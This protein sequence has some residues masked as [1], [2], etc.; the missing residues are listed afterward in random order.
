VNLR[1]L[2]QQIFDL[3][4][5]IS[6]FA[7]RAGPWR[8]VG[9]ILFAFLYYSSYGL[10]GLELRGEG[11]TIAIIAQRILEGERPL[12]DTFLGYNVF[13]FYPIVALFAI[14]GPNF[15]V[16]RLFFYLLSIVTGVLGYRAVWR[17]S[18]RPL[19]SLLAAVIIILIPGMQFRTYMGLLAV[20]NL[21]F[22]LEVFA[23]KNS[24]RSRLI[25]LIGSGLFLGLTFLVRIDLGILFSML[26]LGSLVV[27]PLIDVRIWKRRTRFSA[28]ALAVYAILIVLVQIPVDQFAAQTGFRNEFRSQYVYWINDVTSYLNTVSNGAT[29]VFGEATSSTGAKA[30]PAPVP[31]PK[32]GS[33]TD[34]DS[35]SDHRTRPRPP[36]SD[37][38]LASSSGARHLAF[39]IYYPIAGGVIIVV[40]STLLFLN[41]WRTGHPELNREGFVLLIATGSAL[42]L[43]PQYFLFRPDPPHVSE[44][45]CPFVIAAAIAFHAALPG[46]HPGSR[47]IRFVGVLYT[48]L[49]TIHIAFYIE[50]GIKRPS[51]G[52]CA[53]K[54][55]AEVFFKADNGVSGYLPRDKAAEYQALYQT[56]ID[57][58]APKDYVVCFPYQPMVNFMTNRRSYLY[59]LYVDN[60]SAPPKF[61]EQAIAE[62]AKYKP[63]A[64]LI[65]DVAMNQIPASRFTVWAAPVYQYIKDHYDYAATEAGNEIYLRRRVKPQISQIAPIFG[66]DR[67]PVTFPTL[68]QIRVIC[69]ICGLALLPPTIPL[70]WHPPTTVLAEPP[71]PGAQ[72][73]PPRFDETRSRKLDAVTDRDRVFR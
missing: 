44:M 52:S 22:F 68:P 37:I 1:Q 38:F 63:A 11:G 13:W 67:E 16:V 55:R 35:N 42:T 28:L 18:G 12:A 36:I 4:D 71:F 23:L 29:K 30:K 3:F 61:N 65:D 54:S 46:R 72:T 51:M 21:Y 49:A 2:S 7:E 9:L 17:T 43:L 25:W 5:R 10:S 64:I 32:E 62:I 53:I 50:Y 34:I 59:N 57:H 19:L 41:G 47:T 60:A 40:L 69:A 48:I 24:D 31:I 45:M 66:R 26:A 14:T 70:T 27:Y 39:L 8:I 58:S 20:A 73:S 6:R 33:Q 56:I 15:L